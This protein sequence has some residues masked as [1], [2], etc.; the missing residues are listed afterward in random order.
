[1]KMAFLLA[2]FLS[3]ASMGAS[4][5]LAAGDIKPQKSIAVQPEK[6]NPAAE[7]GKVLSA[8]KKEGKVTIYSSASSAVTTATLQKFRER[9]GI[10]YDIVTGRG[11][12]VSAKIINERRAGLYLAD[13]Y[14][15]GSNTTYSTLKPAGIAES[16]EPDFMLPE[17]KEEEKIKKTWYEGKLPWNDKDHTVFGISLFI[18]PPV[19][20]NTNLV[21]PGEIASYNDLLNQKW[22]K[23]IVSND[24]TIAGVG[25]NILVTIGWHIMGVDWLRALVAQEPT[26]TRNARLQ[27]E[28]VAQGK[29]PIALA[30]GKEQIVDFMEAGAPVQFVTPREGT[31]IS[32]GSGAVTL[33]NK[34]PHPH[35][36]KIFINWLLSREGATV[37]CNS[38]GVQSSRLDV[39]TDDLLPGVIRQAGIKY[40]FSSSEEWEATMGPKAKVLMELFGPLVR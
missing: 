4:Y 1:M 6:A 33:I 35:A 10:D 37:F 28:W 11:P 5:T 39:P 13:V 38:Y 19:G 27:V 16:P 18:G 21:K 15:G 9:Y 7:W 17:L 29:Y 40:P 25:R 14:L 2:A 22:K 36:A 32:T 23:K 12:E 30:P 26:L 20:I 24:P 34:R 31:L 3:Y 8:A